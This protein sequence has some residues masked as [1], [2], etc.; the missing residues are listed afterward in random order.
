MQTCAHVLRIRP[1]GAR[2]NFFISWGYS[3]LKFGFTSSVADLSGPRWPFSLRRRSP[4]GACAYYLAGPKLPVRLRSGDSMGLGPRALFRFWESF[5]GSFEGSVRGSLGKFWGSVG[6]RF[7]ETLGK[8]FGFGGYWGSLSDLLGKDWG[9]IGE[10]WGGVGDLGTDLG[11]IGEV[12]GCVGEA[13]MGM[14]GKRWGR[15]EPILSH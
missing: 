5:E 6:E 9:R 2:R 15:I 4:Q 11:S 7:G 3:L 1:E 8:Y 10:V 13:L 12:L 14:F